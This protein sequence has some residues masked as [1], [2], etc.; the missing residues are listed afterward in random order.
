MFK[1]TFKGKDT[2]KGTSSSSK[3][4]SYSGKKGQSS[5]DTHFNG[6]CLECARFGHMASQCTARIQVLHGRDGLY[7]YGLDS[8]GL[9]LRWLGRLWL[10]PLR[11]GPLWFGPFGL[12]P[13]GLDPCGLDPASHG[14]DPYGLHPQG[15][16][17]YGLDPYGLG[18]WGFHF[19]KLLHFI[20]NIHRERRQEGHILLGT[21][22]GTRCLK[23]CTSP[24]EEI[25]PEGVVLQDITSDRRI[26]FDCEDQPDN[27]DTNQ[28]DDTGPA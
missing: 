12:D 28:V 9:D 13:Y 11:L 5:S 25:L 21:L 24:T 16:D 7:P 14:L 26:I 6:K 23:T 8:Y 1:S 19:S 4:T 2:S 22:P 15:L 18:A 27:I 10:G 20:I 3:N 17:P